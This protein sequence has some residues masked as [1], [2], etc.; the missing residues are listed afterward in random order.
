MVGKPKS[1]GRWEDIKMYLKETG[2]EVVD[3]IRMAQGRSR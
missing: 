2:L 1:L 3:W